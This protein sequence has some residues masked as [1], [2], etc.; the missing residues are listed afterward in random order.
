MV[1]AFERGAERAEAWEDPHTAASGLRVP[2][3]IGDRLML[4]AL[5]ESQGGAVAVSDEALLAL[6]STVTATEGIDLSPEGGAALAA[7]A[8]LAR[9]GDI[10]PDE[11]VVVFNTGAGW[12]YQST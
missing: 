5:R 7:A 11:R 9:R 10:R 1:R 4:Q 12:L 2:G 8:E 6:A 3:P